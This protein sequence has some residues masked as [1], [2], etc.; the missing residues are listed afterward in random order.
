MDWLFHIPLETLILI[1][2][3]KLIKVKTHLSSISFK[4]DITLMANLMA[5]DK[6]Y[7]KMGIL[8]S[9]SLNAMCFKG[10]ES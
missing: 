2:V 9:D 5:L 10:M 8:I 1:T 3:F 7:L 4:E 6:K